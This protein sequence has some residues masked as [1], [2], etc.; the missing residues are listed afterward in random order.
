MQQCIFATCPNVYLPM[1]ALISKPLYYA[2]PNAGLSM[3]RQ[4]TGYPFSTFTIH[5]SLT[6]LANSI[7]ILFNMPPTPVSL[8][9]SMAPWTSSSSKTG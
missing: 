6:A 1:K 3:L 8:K 2:L 4:V 5:D 7:L 9:T